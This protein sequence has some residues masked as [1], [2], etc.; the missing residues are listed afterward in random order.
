[1][2]GSVWVH[3]IVALLG[4]GMMT[5][6]AL[7]LAMGGDLPLIRFPQRIKPTIKF[8]YVVGVIVGLTLLLDFGRSDLLNHILRELA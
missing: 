4:A 7:G 5:I 8:L 6:S 2:E 3:L 1:M